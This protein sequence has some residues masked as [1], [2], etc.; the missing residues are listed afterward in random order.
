M[1][2]ITND[3][4]TAAMLEITVLEAGETPSAEDANWSLQKLQRLCDKLNAYRQAI[5]NVT[6]Q[7]FNLQANQ[8]PTIG[9]T[10]DF[11]ATQRPVR[12]VAASWILN[13]GTGS[14]EA[15]NPIRI[16]DDQWWAANPT[17][18]LTSSIATDLYYSPDEPNGTLNFWPISTV[19]NPVRLELWVNLA[20]PL[21]L[22]TVLTFPQGYWDAIVLSLAL[23][24]CSGFGKEPTPTL[25]R[26]QREAMK[27]IMGNNAPPPRICTDYSMPNSGGW[28]RPDFDYLTGL[29]DN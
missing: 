17:K 15:D 8:T 3:L 29:N 7:V 18:Q 6:F 28:G 21:D 10:G 22:T 26:R 1:N 13:P 5:Y 24:L 16:R 27:I 11:V 12:I 20:I 14:N 9:P 2:V 19:A 4:L 25:D 23:E